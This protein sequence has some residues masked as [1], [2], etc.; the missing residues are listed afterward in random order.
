MKNQFS[1]ALFCD[2]LQSCDSA[3]ETI[4]FIDTSAKHLNSIR[5]MYVQ[6]ATGRDHYDNMLI[7]ITYHQNMRSYSKNTAASNIRS[8]I[9]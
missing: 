4:A 6:H 8:H 5:Y 3:S 9:Y 2:N 1:F 7:K